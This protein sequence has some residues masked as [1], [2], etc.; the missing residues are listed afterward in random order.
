M[1]PIEKFYLI[2]AIIPVVILL[3]IF[4]VNRLKKQTGSS[5]KQ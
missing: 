1:T 4:I 5:G 2:M 3:S